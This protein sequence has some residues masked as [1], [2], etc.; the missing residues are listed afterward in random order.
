MLR[1]SNCA[2]QNL[3]VIVGTDTVHT[4]GRGFGFSMSPEIGQARGS[5]ID[6][7]GFGAF[8]AEGG[9]VP[10]IHFIDRVTG[11]EGEVLWEHPE[12]DPDAD[13]L[14]IS[15]C[16]VNSVLQENVRF[17]TG[18]RAQ[19]DG[20]EPA[21]KTGT[22]PDFTD[23]WFLGYT[24]QLV[25][26]VYMGSNE[27]MQTVDGGVN[28]TGG[29]LPAQAWAEFNELALA[30]QTAQPFA[31]C[32]PAE[33]SG[34]FS[35]TEADHPAN[36]CAGSPNFPYPVDEDGDG[37]V[38]RCDEASQGC[39][40]SYVAIDN[41]A[42]G[43]A[44][45]CVFV[46]AGA[47]PVEPTAAVGSGPQCPEDYPFP[48]DTDFDGTNDACFVGE[49]TLDP[50]GECPSDQMIGIDSAGGAISDECYSIGAVPPVLGSC[51]SIY[52]EADDNGDGSTDRCVFRP[53]PPLPPGLTAATS[54]V[55]PG[56]PGVCPESHPNGY[57]VDG[58]G[59]IDSCFLADELLQSVA[60]LP[61]LE[62]GGELS[63]P[64]DFPWP[65][66]NDGDGVIDFC[67]ARTN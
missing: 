27:P 53:I 10:D 51:P 5:L 2:F 67:Q 14:N 50:A 56:A 31:T 7:A 30:N 54:P 9:A 15:V 45:E 66:E 20:H 8:L 65:V 55:P 43:V 57:D 63:C 21:G 26:V 25:T 64:P 1:S 3:L 12:R 47:V 41:N 61:P 52:S 59:A 4:L 42:D 35:G 28:I 48:A 39:P 13:L 44:D 58:D 60:P 40:A 18:I 24:P 37:A 32:D 36:S 38:D 62:P 17:G 29:S 6:V 49:I 19:V 16:H 33:R 11:S 34:S 46:G 23:A 22:T